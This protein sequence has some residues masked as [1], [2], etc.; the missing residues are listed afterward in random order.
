MLYCFKETVVENRLSS[1]SY[2]DPACLCPANVRNKD[3]KCFLFVFKVKRG[4]HQ[5]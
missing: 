5:P 3:L 1:G 4:M 2:T